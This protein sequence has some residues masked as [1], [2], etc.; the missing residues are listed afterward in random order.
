M[1]GKALNNT[2]LKRLSAAAHWLQRLHEAPDDASLQARC[3]RWR[4][5][6]SANASA[7]ARMQAVWQGFDQFA[8]SGYAGGD[9]CQAG[10]SSTPGAMLPV[11][12]PSAVTAGECSSVQREI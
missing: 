12:N 4:E 3:R 2:T 6:K 5:A 7:F 11:D 9:A 1:S 10:F 8:R